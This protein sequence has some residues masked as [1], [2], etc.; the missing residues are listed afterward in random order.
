MAKLADI[1]HEIDLD[2]VISY[3]VKI[4]AGEV[5]GRIVVKIS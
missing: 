3:G 4:L 5:R 2:E 1:T